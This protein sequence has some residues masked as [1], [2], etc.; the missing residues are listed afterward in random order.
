MAMKRSESRSIPRSPGKVARGR[1]FLPAL[2]AGMFLALQ[3]T[4]QPATS[5]ASPDPELIA[6]HLERLARAPSIEVVIPR[7]YRLDTVGRRP[8]LI[9]TLSTPPPGWK[10][11]LVALLRE[12]GVLRRAVD[13]LTIYGDDQIWEVRSSR[14]PE[15]ITLVFDLA[16]GRVSLNSTGLD[17]VSTGCQLI[18]DRLRV[19]F[20]S[21]SKSTWGGR[22]LGWPGPSASAPRLLTMD[23]ESRALRTSKTRPDTVWYRA[24]ISSRGRVESVFPRTIGLV[25]D[26]TERRAEKWTFIPALLSGRPIGARVNLGVPVAPNQRHD[27][28]DPMLWATATARSGTQPVLVTADSLLL[29]S[30]R[31]GGAPW[32]TGRVRVFVGTD[33]L[34]RDVRVVRSA[35]GSDGLIIRAVRRSQYRPSVNHGSPV[36]SWTEFEVLVSAS[37]RRVWKPPASASG[38]DTSRAP[39]KELPERGEFVYYED[40]PVKLEGPAPVYP[41]TARAAGVR[42]NVVLH[43][44][45]GR[46]GRVKAVKVIRS[47]AGL[48]EAATQAVSRWVYKPAL[49]NNK[50]VAVWI[51]VSV[52]FPPSG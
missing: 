30:L 8:E 5:R 2:V 25:D 23:P 36:A 3:G 29:E 51:E 15:S 41:E 4:A 43:I 20:R 50:P 7:S 1:T 13:S 21:L 31:T 46:D 27:G 34:V 12:P 42:G 22:S 40:P 52:P 14:A 16:P 17:P 47:V 39:R 9:A 37:R 32:D 49:S 45:I 18:A 19:L 48:D 24:D 26:A 6:G 35:P 11:S 33:G 28:V 38:A 44:L 10:E